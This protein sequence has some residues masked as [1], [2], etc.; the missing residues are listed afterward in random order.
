M[1][2]PLANPVGICF[3]ARGQVMN[4]DDARVV[5]PVSTRYTNSCFLM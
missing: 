2:R 1:A 4:R 5:P 3:M